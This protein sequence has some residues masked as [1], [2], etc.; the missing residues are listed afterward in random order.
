MQKR[1][2]SMAIAG[3]T[4]A[5]LLA[6]APAA[7]AKVPPPDGGNGSVQ[8]VTLSQSCTWQ[9][10]FLG[11]VTVTFKATF[12][13]DAKRQRVR[14]FSWTLTDGYTDSSAAYTVTNGTTKL[15][16]KGFLDNGTASGSPNAVI[17]KN[18]RAIRFQLIHAASGVCGETLTAPR[19]DHFGG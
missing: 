4:A 10:D 17:N 1:I 8:Y 15:V 9:P 5:S 19:W 14:L 18:K 11:D 13:V 12:S 16:E 2:M 6:F 7:L 3:A